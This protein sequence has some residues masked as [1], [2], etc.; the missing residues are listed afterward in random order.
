[1][2]RTPGPITDEEIAWLREHRVKGT[3]PEED[4]GTTVSRMRDEDW[5]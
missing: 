3:P 5:P 2:V 1:V 4:A